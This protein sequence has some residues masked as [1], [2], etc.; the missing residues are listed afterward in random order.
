[1][2]QKMYD[3]IKPVKLAH[4]GVKAPHKKFTAEQATVMI[5]TME[6]CVISEEMPSRAMRPQRAGSG[7]IE[8]FER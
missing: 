6:I 4:G 1:M 3:A 2:S 8:R 5:M 7:F